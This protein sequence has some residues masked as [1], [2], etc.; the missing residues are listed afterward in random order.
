MKCR[1]SYKTLS[2][3]EDY[4]ISE[5][6]HV[7]SVVSLSSD[8]HYFAKKGE[9]CCGLSAVIIFQIMNSNSLIYIVAAYQELC[10]L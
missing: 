8:K 6:R 3:V 10:L 1:V 5:I 4:F 2:T 7:S 9:C